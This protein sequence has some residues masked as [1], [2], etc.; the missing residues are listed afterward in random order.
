MHSILSYGACER[1]LYVCTLSYRAVPV[2]ASVPDP[3]PSGT[4]VEKC[5][6]LYGAR[7]AAVFQSTRSVGATNNARGSER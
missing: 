2:N 5:S 1:G 3:R 4:A 6:R 7:W